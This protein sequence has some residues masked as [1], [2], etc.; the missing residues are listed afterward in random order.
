MIFNTETV[1]L[2]ILMLLGLWAGSNLV[3]SSAAI[4]LVILLTR[5]N[6][7]FPIL[8]HR[9]VEI[10]L[11]FLTLAMLVPFAMGRVDLKELGQ[12]FLTL[13][14][15][16]TLVGGAVATHLNGHGLKMLSDNSHM[17]V[18]LIVGSIIGIVVWG[19][20]PV[21]PLMAAGVTYVLLEVIHW[22]VRVLG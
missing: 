2:L 10:G 6:F 3:V 22:V 14:G 21:G 11:L 17:M 5:M 15:I 18:G 1:G 9:G 16:M 8:E 19:G 7:L 4:L 12:S 13:P 20:I